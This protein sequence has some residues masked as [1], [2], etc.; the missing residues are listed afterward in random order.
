[1]TDADRTIEVKIASP[2]K[3]VLGTGLAKSFRE[4]LLAGSWTNYVVVV[5]RVVA[6]EWKDFLWGIFDP[7]KII[8]IDAGEAQKNINLVEKLW[9]E[10]LSNGLDRKSLVFNIGGGSLTDVGGFA[11]STFMRGIDFIQVPTTLL[12]QVDAS[13]GGKTGIN[14]CS[15]KNLIGSFQQPRK[16]LI[17]VQFL[18][19][20][21]KRS[22]LSGAA[23]M[24]KH[25]VILS[26]KHF[27]DVVGYD[28]ETGATQG[29][30]NLIGDSVQIKADVVSQDEKEAGLR[31]LLNFGHTVGHA[32]ESLALEQGVS[33]LHGEA[34]ALGML[35]E[36][37]LAQE[38]R[39]SDNATFERIYRGLQK[40]GLPLRYPG[41][42]ESRRIMEI[43]AR[44][45]K[46]MGGRINFSLPVVVGQSLP[47]QYPTEKAIISALSQVLS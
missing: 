21:D 28:W 22:L 6:I 31:K 39:V 33:L 37:K 35:V 27:E 17:D 26:E 3:V 14:F 47:D 42:V 4:L 5:D 44:D 40:L 34:V 46:N 11:A 24:V 16:V 9:R 7:V 30:L 10:F 29:L 12:A 8:E 41:H 38:E 32:L 23:E 2:Y 43:M 19:S 25:G 45:K 13:V 20:L 15:V 1:M 18:K 36:A